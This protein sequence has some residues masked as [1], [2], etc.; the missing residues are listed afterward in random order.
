MSNEM[1]RRYCGSSSFSCSSYSHF[2]LFL[3]R[4]RPSGLLPFKI[5]LKLWI[6]KKVGKTPWRGS[7]RCKAATNRTRKTPEKQ[8]YINA[9]SGV[10]LHG[11]AAREGQDISFLRRHCHC[12]RLWLTKI[13]NSKRLGRSSPSLFP[14]LPRESDNQ[15]HRIWSVLCRDSIQVLPE[16]T[17]NCLCEILIR[18][19]GHFDGRNN[20]RLKWSTSGQLKELKGH[21][22]S[23][24]IDGA[25]IITNCGLN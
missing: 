24:K 2:F 7:A 16:D 19:R 13:N 25:V 14:H 6:L 15:L 10:G 11:P 21:Q 18:G 20:G 17:T 4:I 1:W 9:S 22:Q 8:T 3:W 5:N 12:N 23:R